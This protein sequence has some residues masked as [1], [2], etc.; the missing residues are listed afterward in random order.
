[1]S[2]ER[3]RKT[4]VEGFFLAVERLSRDNKRA[5]A[6]NIAEILGVAN[7]TASGS[8]RELANAG[9]IDHQPY[10][11]AILTERGRN[12]LLVV[13][14][15]RQ[16]LELFLVQTLHLQLDDATDESWLIEPAATEFLIERINEYLDYPK[17]DIRGTSILVSANKHTDYSD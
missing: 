14:R 9:W 17:S 10:A 15:K 13:L 1:M 5:S 16:L 11:G 4:R 6:G 3:R 2:S 8:I 7:G 12:R